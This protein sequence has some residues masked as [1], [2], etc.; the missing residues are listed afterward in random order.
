MHIRRSR[1]LSYPIIEIRDSY[2]LSRG[3]KFSRSTAFTPVHHTASPTARLLADHSSSR[4][5]FMLTTSCHDFLP[6]R[7]RS[8]SGGLRRLVPGTVGLS[9]RTLASVS[10]ESSVRLEA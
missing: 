6:R 2:V 8:A 3:N 4:I 5:V 1:I 10:S 7:L 9:G